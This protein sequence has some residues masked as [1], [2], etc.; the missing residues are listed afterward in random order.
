LTTTKA[1]DGVKAAVRSRYGPP[2]VLTVQ[3][4]TTPVPKDD[5]VLIRVHAASVNRSDYHVLTGSPWPMRCFTGL[6]RPTLASTGT[7]FAG[8]IESTGSKV[9]K[10]KPGENV[11]GFGGV[12]GIGSHAQYLALSEC[13]GIVPM[14]ANIT[15]VQ[16]AACLEGAYYAATA[17]T[18]VK[19]RAGQKALVYGATGAIGSAYVQLLKCWGLYV[20][21]VCAGQHRQLVTSL[22]ADK[23]VDYTT[24]DFTRDTER[25]DLVVDAVAKTSYAA[26]RKLMQNH[27]V[28]TSSGGLEN[29]F[30]A[31]ATGL[32]GRKRVLFIG[33]KD[34]VGN[35]MLVKDLV[36]QGRFKPVVD[37]QYPIE[38]ISE[39]FAYVG[40]GQKIGNVIV[41][42][43]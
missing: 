40:T 16:A 3:E 25:Y 27:G 30:L 8:R 2:E 31:V 20:T 12:F 41:T 42:M 22:G 19:P 1:S 10:F 36:E 11:M 43:D 21:A 26:C 17:L 7:D 37:R 33:P 35:L 14:P 38:K 24:Q 23:V 34:I 5:E 9:R 29:L 4:I 39:A 28:Y 15:Y 13:R 18:Q 32:V 6:I